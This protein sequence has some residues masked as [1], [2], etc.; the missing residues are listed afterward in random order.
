MPSRRTALAILASGAAAACSPFRLLN[1]LPSDPARRIAEDV[2]YGADSRQ[3]L[4]VWAPAQAR[5]GLPVLVFFYGGS[6]SS[7]AKRDYAFAARALAA[8]GFVVIVPDYRLV[9]AVRFPAFVEDAAQATAFAHAHAAQWG[10]DPARLAVGGHSAGAYL[11]AMVALDPSWLERAGG[12]RGAVKV[13]AGLSGPYDFFPF[14]VDA[15]RDAF[16]AWPRPEETQPI[17]YA[18]PGDPPA[19]LAHGLKDTTVRPRNTE[20]LAAKLKAAGVD[21]EVRRYPDLDH[22]DTVLALTRTFRGK[23]PVRADM[24]RF[25]HSR[26]GV[27]G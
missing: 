9:P 1:A 8:E 4:D 13:W 25:L 24:S 12:P 23:A 17:T 11:A 21:V 26:L 15:S 3:R 14:D 2:P 7:G 19:F 16:A 10:G 5:A 27:R 20:V 18:G 22:K 6:W